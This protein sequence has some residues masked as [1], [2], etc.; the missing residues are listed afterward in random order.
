MNPDPAT[1]PAPETFG[2]CKL[3]GNATKAYFDFC[4]ACVQ[5]ERKRVE[6]TPETPTPLT[7]E[8]WERSS[9]AWQKHYETALEKIADLERA[10]A[11]AKREVGKVNDF[12]ERLRAKHRQVCDER[13]QLSSLAHQ[14]KAEIERLKADKERAQ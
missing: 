6:A 5:K 1:N 12:R 9:L 4:E 3:C 8:A 7:L 13:D 2:R 10:L 14:L 11:D